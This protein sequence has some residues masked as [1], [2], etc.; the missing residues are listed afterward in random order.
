MMRNLH[1]ALHNL[2]NIDH[3][4]MSDLLLSFIRLT[5]LFFEFQFYILT[6]D[7]L[8]IARLSFHFFCTK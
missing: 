1:T 2:C 3:V 6:E 7:L 5:F 4:N 8:N